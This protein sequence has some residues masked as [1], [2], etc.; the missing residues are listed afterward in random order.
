MPRSRAVPFA[1]QTGA[2]PPNVE[3]LERVRGTDPASADAT[4][5]DRWLRPDLGAT[6]RISTGGTAR[7]AAGRHLTIC[8][9]VPRTDTEGL[10][11]TK[12]GNAVTGKVIQR[13]TGPAG[14]NSGLAALVTGGPAIR[15]PGW[16]RHRCA[17]K[18]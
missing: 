2:A 5:R 10:M 14:V 7:R 16:I 17:R 1:V 12:I 9:P 15:R 11:T 8:F 6:G 3:R 13:I 18:T 4:E